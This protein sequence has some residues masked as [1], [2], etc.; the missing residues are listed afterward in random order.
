MTIL[1]LHTCMPNIQYLYDD[2]LLPQIRMLQPHYDDMHFL[3]YL[4][5]HISIIT[6]Q[7]RLDDLTFIP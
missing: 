6:Y 5:Q 3:F 1:N 7:Y 4:S 2:L